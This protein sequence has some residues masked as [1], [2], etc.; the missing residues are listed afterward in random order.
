MFRRGI[1][2][3]TMLFV[4][5]GNVYAQSPDPAVKII[6]LGSW[7][8]IA[9]CPVWKSDL[10]DEFRQN[11][12]TNIPTVIVH[13][14]WD[15]STP[16]ENAL[17]LVPYFKE[18][19]FIPVIRGPH[20]AIRAAIRASEKFRK[21]IMHFAATGDMSDLPDEVEIPPVKWVVP[22]VVKKQENTF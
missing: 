22:E 1:L 18:S 8:Y 20:G 14:T 16:Y 2:I 9:G 4:I 12:E 17:E 21:G 3:F 6:G 10:G 7:G 15:T 11:F 19:K 13:G 5:A